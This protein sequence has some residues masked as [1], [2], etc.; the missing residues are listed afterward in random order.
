MTHD[1]AFHIAEMCEAMIAAGEEVDAATRATPAAERLRGALYSDA[2]DL[3]GSD[4]PAQR[5]S[6]LP[7]VVAGVLGG[8]LV[9]VLIG[10]DRVVRARRTSQR[11]SAPWYRQ[12]TVRRHLRS[13]DLANPLRV[14]SPSVGR[15]G[16]GIRSNSP[17]GRAGR[18]P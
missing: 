5:S 2:L 17:E 1:G 13:F 11:Y 10:G 18:P 12:D 8:I 4:A 9:G 7:W 15:F 6:M 16:L 3:I 14:A